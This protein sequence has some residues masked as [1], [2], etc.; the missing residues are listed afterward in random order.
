MLSTPQIYTVF[1]EFREFEKYYIHFSLAKEVCISHGQGLR[2]VHAR[3]SQYVRLLRQE[4]TPQ[5]IYRLS[6][7]GVGACKTLATRPP[8]IPWIALK[9]FCSESWQRRASYR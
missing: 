5:Q 6:T 7:R 9:S 8:S 2:D 4:W 3:H 1:K